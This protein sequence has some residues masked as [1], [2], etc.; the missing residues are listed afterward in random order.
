[1]AEDIEASTGYNGEVHI[2]DGTDLYELVGVTGFGL[3]QNRR[4]RVDASTLKDLRPVTIPGRYESGEFTVSLLYRPGSTTDTL[5]HELN[6]SS[7]QRAMK[8]AIPEQDGSITEEWSFGGE[9]TGYEQDELSTDS[10]MMATVTIEVQT[11]ITRAAPS[12][13]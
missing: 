3:P 7:E 1:M 9:V 2:N 5:L 10:A 11:P 6:E 12:A 13:P 4:E 8:I